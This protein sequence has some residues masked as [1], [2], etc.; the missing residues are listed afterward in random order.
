M[1]KNDHIKVI[2]LGSL[3]CGKTCFVKWYC[4]DYFEEEYHPTVG[5][6]YGMKVFEMKKYKLALSFFDLSGD[7]YFN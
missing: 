3:G 5:L 1:N 7:D 2:T 6:D 4:E